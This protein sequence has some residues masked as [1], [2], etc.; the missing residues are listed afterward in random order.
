[1]KGVYQNRA[2]N[3]STGEGAQDGD[4]LSDRKVGLPVGSPS[5]GVTISMI[6]PPDECTTGIKPAP[7]KPVQSTYSIG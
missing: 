4:K 7:F 6:G 3:W 5:S 2:D 1:M